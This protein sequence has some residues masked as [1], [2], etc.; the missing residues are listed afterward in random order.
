MS[1]EAEYFDNLTTIYNSSAT[2]APEERFL[3]CSVTYD[4]IARI[5]ILKRL[6]IV[7]AYTIQIMLTTV[8]NSLSIYVNF[9][10]KHWKN[11]SMRMVLYIS[12]IDIL[13]AV[14]GSTAQIVHIVVP[15][16]L[17]CQ[18][19]TYLMFFPHLLVHLSMYA[20][21]F[22]A[23]DRFLHVML[24]RRY[25]NVVTPYKYHSVLAIYLCTG[26]ITAAI[27]NFGSTFLG[28]N[29][30]TTYS[31]SINL[32]FVTG[33]TSIYIASIA[34]LKIYQKTSRKVSAN[35]RSLNKMTTSFL[36]II[37]ITFTPIFVFAA[38]LVQIEKEIGNER[39]IILYHSLI[40]LA[41]FNSSLN[42]LAYLRLNAEAK[43]RINSMINNMIANNKNI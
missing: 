29:G 6:I 23:L 7:G 9:A 16:H 12:V 41:N 42:A 32:L 36:A 34:K 1:L 38:F 4:G 26:V 37:T 39:A 40:F 10:T 22:V 11:Q 25:K 28:E 21:M 13:Y 30:N 2:E 31:A 8:I 27:L 3:D 24:L 18:Q 35:T 20:V 43:R 19:R 15:N 33:T 14:F 17:N 5:P